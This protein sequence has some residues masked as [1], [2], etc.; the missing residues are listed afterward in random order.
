MELLDR[1]V[2]DALQRE[3][4]RLVRLHRLSPEAQHDT[5]RLVD[6]A[7]AEGRREPTAG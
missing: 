1:R 3:F 7:F 5:A 4:D 2:S 6:R